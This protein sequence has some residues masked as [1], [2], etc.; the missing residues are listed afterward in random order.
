MC[1]QNINS[2]LLSIRTLSSCK[3]M[4]LTSLNLY[5]FGRLQSVW[6]WCKLGRVGRPDGWHDSRR[7]FVRLAGAW[8]SCGGHRPPSPVE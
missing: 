6:S 4:R 5:S 1:S 8:A 2:A 7:S 3:V